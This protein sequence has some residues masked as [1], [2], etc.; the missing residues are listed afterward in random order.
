M[1]SLSTNYKCNNCENGVVIYKVSGKGKSNELTAE[2]KSCNR[3]FKQ[4]GLKSLSSL[5]EI[6]P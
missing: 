1:K 5:K 2:V 4:F 6:K 3:C